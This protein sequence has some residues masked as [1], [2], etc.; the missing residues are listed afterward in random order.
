MKYEMA[1]VGI[2]CGVISVV[3]G[4]S[5][6]NAA[7]ASPCC[8]SQG[9]RQSA[10]KAPLPP[11]ENA[12]VRKAGQAARAF[13]EFAS[14]KAASCADALEKAKNF[15]LEQKAEYLIA[16]ARQFL[17][18]HEWKEAIAAAQYVLKEIDERSPQAQKM[19]ENAQAQLAA[20]AKTAIGELGKMLQDFA[21]RNATS[22]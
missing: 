2:V 10:G 14:V 4:C 1:I 11:A 18:A 7:S 20:Q 5:A 19:I 9:L 22:Q 3:S 21:A 12:A 16:Q 6:G 13:T 17:D 15:P 8:S